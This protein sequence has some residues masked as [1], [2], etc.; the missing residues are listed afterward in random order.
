MSEAY[1][2]LSITPIKK[3]YN[4]IVNKDGESAS[5]F[6]TDYLNEVGFFQKDIDE[7]TTDWKSDFKVHRDGCFS[8][9][10]Q[11]RTN[12]APPTKQQLKNADRIMKEITE[13]VDPTTCEVNS[14]KRR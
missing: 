9:R 14:E 8:Y 6:P 1:V 10:I 3:N 13:A 2:V 12:T 4:G 7:V 5:A 11:I